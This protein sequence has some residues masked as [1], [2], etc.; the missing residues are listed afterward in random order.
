MRKIILVSILLLVLFL[1]SA[2]QYALNALRADAEQKVKIS[3]K[4][5]TLYSNGL[6]LSLSTPLYNPYLNPNIVYLKIQ[7]EPGSLIR[8]NGED[9]S[10]VDGRGILETPL[11]LEDKCSGENL[12]SIVSMKE[13]HLTQKQLYINAK[14]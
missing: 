8:I 13:D 9:R 3:T 12:F 5:S 10:Y 11:T 4:V 7:S 6:P 2:F 14:C 1:V